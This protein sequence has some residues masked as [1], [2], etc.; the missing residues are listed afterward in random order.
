[1]C[2][3]KLCVS[4]NSYGGSKTRFA[5]VR[6]GNV[7]GSRGSIVETLLRLVKES[8]T[9]EITHEDM[10]RFWIHLS[11]AYQL[12]MFAL[13]HMVGGEIFIPQIPSMKLVDLVDAIAPNNERRIVATAVAPECEQIIVG[14]RPGEKMHEILLTEQEARHAKD[15]MGCYV[16]IP[17]FPF[18]EPNAYEKYHKTGTALN[19]GDSFVSSDNSKWITKEDLQRIIE[20]K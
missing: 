10:T 12:V 18:W 16:V 9:V 11:Q 14:I 8:G 5:V 3:E 19:H 2:A 20:E 17:E 15:F 4:S 13:E 7:I 1:M 6:Y